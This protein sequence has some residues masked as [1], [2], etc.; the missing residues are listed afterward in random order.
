MI[1]YMDTNYNFISEE[2]FMGQIKEFCEDENKNVHGLTFEQAMEKL[3]NYGVAVFLEKPRRK[4]GC[5]TW[6]RFYMADEEVFEIE[7]IV[8]DNESDPCDNDSF[9]IAFAIY[10]AGWRKQK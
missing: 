1:K 6:A 4:N 10:K 5:M 7:D 8:I 9:G 3:N 2:K